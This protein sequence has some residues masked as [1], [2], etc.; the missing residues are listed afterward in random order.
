MDIVY[1]L[2]TLTVWFLSTYFVVLVLLVVFE[3]RKDM[4]QNRNTSKTPFVSIVMPAYNEESSILPA[5]KSL[6]DI[7][8]PKDKYEVIVVNDGSNDRTCD[9][10][11]HFISSQKTT[12]FVYI[13]RK[14]NKG[15]AHSLNEGIDAAQGEFVGTMDSDSQVKPD[16]LRKT[17]GLFADSK[18]GAVTVRVHVQDPKNLLER[19]VDL[20]YVV[21]LSLSNRILSYLDCMHVTPG[22]FSIYRM[23]MMK[24]IGGFDV[25]N[26][27]ED[28]EI[29]FRIHKARYR[30]VNT[31]ST[32]VYTKVPSTFGALYKQ[33]KRWYTG[34]LDTLMQHP[35]VLFNRR[36]GAFGLFFLPIN[37]AT[38][39]LG[40]VLGLYSFWMLLS[41]VLKNIQYLIL[42]NFEILP[43]TF[44]DIDILK[45]SLF[46]FLMV[47]SIIS[48]L[49]LTKASMSAVQR[50]LRENVL[51]L[52]GFVLFFIPY[53]IFWLSSFYSVFTGKK[54]KWR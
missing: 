16:I 45:L 49:S 32:G 17:V 8:Y 10:I 23:T 6:C 24:E 46:H 15:K 38:I 1:T 47:G 26:I 3:K 9:I 28:M 2:L 21:G 33:R 29:A 53:Q 44:P 12:T 50:R 14:E 51:A 35:D 37:Y 5:L 27:T 7:D 22:P 40:L 31:L 36:L 39:T 48:V 42:T 25:R 20:E 43:F 41:T 52:A 30:I 54:V 4:R 34:S 18:V 11:G 13:N 19:I